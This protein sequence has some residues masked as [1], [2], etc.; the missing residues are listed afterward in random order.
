M[1]VPFVVFLYIFLGLASLAAIVTIVNLYHLFRFGFLSFAF[2]VMAILAVLVPAAI[3][4]STFTTL[5]DV[6]WQNTVTVTLPQLR[7]SDSFTT[8]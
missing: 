1:T 2:V 4:L 7:P 3:L 5:A 6:D 8:P